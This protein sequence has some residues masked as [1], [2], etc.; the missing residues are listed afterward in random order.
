MPVKGFAAS[1]WG[2]SWIKALEEIDGDTNRLPRGRTYA[3]NGSVLEITQNIKGAIQARVQVRRATPYK[4]RLSLEQWSEE[5]IA[6]VLDLIK[7]HPA[8]SS[9]PSSG[10]CPKRSNQC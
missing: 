1:W 6:T 2:K 4:I 8:V 3:R 5:Q 10:R 7:D 9:Q